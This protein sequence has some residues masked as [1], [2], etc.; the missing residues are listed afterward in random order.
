MTLVGSIAAAWLDTD[1]SGCD[2]MFIPADRQVV[3]GQSF[4]HMASCHMGEVYI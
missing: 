4:V 2:T 1:G 3:S